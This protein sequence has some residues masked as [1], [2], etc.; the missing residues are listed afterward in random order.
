MLRQRYP[1]TGQANAKVTLAILALDTG[2][3]AWADLGP[4]DQ[5]L[6]R[7]DWFP[8]G[9]RLVVQHQSRDQK[10]LDVVAFPVSGGVGQVLWAEQ[11]DTW[12]DLH[13]DL[14]FLPARKEILWV[15]SR[16]GHDHLYR[17]GYDGALKGAVTAGEWD[18][19]AKA[20]RPSAA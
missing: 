3:V 7:V 5:Y 19:M 4:E 11:S 16:S 9:D 18:V 2:K 6:A 20:G 1:A 13:D 14:H 17:Y 10:R 8:E 12:I 15:S